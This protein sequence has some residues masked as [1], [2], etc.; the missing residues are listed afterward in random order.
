MVVLDK[1]F[2]TNLNSL[3]TR[4]DQKKEQLA[5][6]N[7]EKERLL[8]FFWQNKKSKRNIWNWEKHIKSYGVI[9]RGGGVSEIYHLQQ[10]RKANEIA[11]E[12]IENEKFQRQELIIEQQIKLSVRNFRSKA[13]NT[14]A[15][16]S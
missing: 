6:K 9:V 11:S 2:S 10:V 16:V 8:N 14:E 5:L 4:L 13:K 12:I 3:Q 1:N 7:L 15:L